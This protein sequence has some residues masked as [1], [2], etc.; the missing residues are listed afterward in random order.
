MMGCRWGA[1]G[2]NFSEELN[3][4]MVDCLSVT[5]FGKFW[6][7]VFV[8]CGDSIVCLDCRILSR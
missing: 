4:S 1:L 7:S 3:G 6:N 8:R 2:L 5:C